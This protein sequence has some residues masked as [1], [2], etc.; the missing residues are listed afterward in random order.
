MEPR[1]P[2]D[3]HFFRIRGPHAAFDL[4]FLSA[5]PALTP[6]FSLPSVAFA[7]NVCISL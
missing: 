6:H 7:Y 2:D 5:I 3:P 1:G 4:H